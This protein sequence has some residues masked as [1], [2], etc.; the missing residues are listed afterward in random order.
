MQLSAVVVSGAGSL[1]GFGSAVPNTENGFCT[2]TYATY[3]G[4]ALIAVRAGY[5]AGEAT[6]TVKAEGLEPAEISVRVME[7]IMEDC[8]INTIDID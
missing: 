3:H 1:Q 2:G 5:Q 6:V 7:R 8:Y 4:R